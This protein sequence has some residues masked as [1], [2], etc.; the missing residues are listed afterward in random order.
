MKY[1]YIASGLALFFVVSSATSAGTATT[2]PRDADMASAANGLSNE[3]LQAVDQC[4]LAAALAQRVLEQ[5]PGSPEWRTKLLVMAADSPKYAKEFGDD[6]PD[7][8][9]LMIAHLVIENAAANQGSP[10]PRI[11]EQKAMGT[12][13]AICAL[14]SVRRTG[15]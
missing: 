15:T 1:L 6:M 12:A 3:E 8:S 5:E 11:Q 10:L 4:T 7:S 2:A 14:R 9:Q 13:A